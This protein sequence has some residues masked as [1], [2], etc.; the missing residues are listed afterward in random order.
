MPS[1]AGKTYC[2]YPYGHHLRASSQ[3]QGRGSGTEQPECKDVRFSDYFYLRCFDC[4]TMRVVRRFDLWPAK[5]TPAASQGP[6]MAPNYFD[7][8]NRLSGELF[9]TRPG[10]PA[11]GGAKRGGGTRPR[12][13]RSWRPGAE[14]VPLLPQS[15][16]SYGRSSTSNRQLWVPRG[17]AR[18]GVAARTVFAVVR[19]DPARSARRLWRVP[20]CDSDHGSSSGRRRSRLCPPGHGPLGVLTGVGVSGPTWRDGLAVGRGKRSG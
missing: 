15:S 1:L 18:D 14:P 10:Q 12:P 9:G 17:N 20:Q 7:S 13:R 11:E 3:R 6:R 16:P 19:E 2:R 5:R 4:P 8:M